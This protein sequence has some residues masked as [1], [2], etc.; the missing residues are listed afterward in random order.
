MSDYEHIKGR[1][2]PLKSGAPLEKQCEA[3][4]NKYGWEKS[5]YH[6]DYEELM[7]DEGYRKVFIHDDVIYEIVDI[8]E[9]DPYEDIAIMA[10]NQN[11]SLSFEVRWYNGGASMSEVIEEAFKCIDESPPESPPKSQSETFTPS[12]DPRHV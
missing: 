8:V 11:E 12:D 2:V 5:S 6:E 7:L 9:V 1:L 3:I 4:C 10:K